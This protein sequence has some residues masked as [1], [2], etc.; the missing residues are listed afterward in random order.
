MSRTGIREESKREDV[1]RYV[2]QKYGTKPEYPWRTSPDNLVLRHGDNRKWYG[3][4]MA[5]K[6]ENLRLPGNGYIDILDIKCDPEMAGFLTV[7]K[8]ILPGYHMHK[9]N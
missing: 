2:L 4:I 3:L 5:V 6:R 1:L 8:G 7:E 9:G